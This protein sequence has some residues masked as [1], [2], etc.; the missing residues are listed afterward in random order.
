MMLAWLVI[1]PL[2]A[3]VLSWALARFSAVV[4]RVLAL[5][6]MI[7]Q[8]GLSVSLWRQGLPADSPWIAE[9]QAS[10]IPQLGISF[11][12]ALDGLS[13]LLIL[14]TGLLGIVS[15]LISWSEITERV[16][17]FHL[18]LLWVLAGVTGVF[19]ALD[20]FLFYFF[21]ELMLIPMY[22]LI[23]L[24][25]HERRHYAAVKFFL[26]TQ[27]SGLLMLLA[28]LGLFFIHVWQ[29]GEASFDYTQLLGTYCGPVA[30]ML[31]LLGFVIAFAVK[32]PVVPLHTWLPDAHTQA[33]TAG[34]VILAGLLLK[35]G[36]YGLIRF[37]VPLFPEAALA[38]T[39]PA[40]ILGVIGI[41]YG[42]YMAFAQTDLKRLVAYSSVSHLGFVFLGVFAWNELALQGAV[43]QMLAH[44]LS[45]GALFVLAG[46]VQQR[47]HTRDMSDLGGLWKAVPMLGGALIFF[48]MASLGLPGMGNFIGEFLT[49]LGAFRVNVT[50]AVIAGAGLVLALVYSLWLVDRA[51][52]GPEPR[53]Y[54]IAD[55]RPHEVLVV[56]LL[57]VAILWLGLVP[58][59]F[60][61]LSS[62]VIG[63]L[64]A[65]GGMR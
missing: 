37:A 25:G 10:W 65:A 54:G 47:L 6:A 3:G 41:V 34:S 42:A 26:F 35:T 56:A 45:T 24:W 17:L 27:L 18:N 62:P 15:V 48:A 13:L 29:G 59:P 30:G 11:H 21:W 50:L 28:I 32:L 36:G 22:F 58:Q 43:I 7:A 44:G 46:I 63:G 55:L 8:L 23:D 9:L 61:D 52:Y 16:G 49:L 12:L 40:L 4:A 5:A 20:L 57:G 60:L 51:V 14:L 33:P 53:E 2:A 64:L 19:L 31:L 1:I 38:L 39:T